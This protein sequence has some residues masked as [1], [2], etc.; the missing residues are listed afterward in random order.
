VELGLTG[1]RALVTGSSRGTGTLIARTLAREGATVVVHGNAEGDQGRIAGE[2]ELSGGAA[3]AVTG[4]ITT[5]EGAEHVVNLTIGLVGG[6][7]ILVNNFGGPSAGRWLTAE[8]ADWLAAYQANT[9]SAVRMIRGFVGGMKERGFGRVIQLATIGASRPNSRMPEYY[10]AKAALVNLTVSLA[11]EL[12]GTGVTVNA[13]SPGLIHTPEVEAYL[14]HLAE[15]RGWG[16]SWEE[17]EP[18]GVKELTGTP[19]GRL[20]RP[21]EVADLVAF[22]ASER[23]GYVHGGNIRIDGGATDSV[24]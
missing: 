4:D 24:Q 1:K 2:I 13:V 17:I 9:L 6:I 23:A 16:D 12:A 7:D 21:E 8:T 15:K 20:A 11:K 3:H 10:A 22:L 19:A 5:D 18:R 14:K